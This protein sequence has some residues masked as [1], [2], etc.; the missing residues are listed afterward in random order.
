MWS[1]ALHPV[2]HL[3]W[4]YRPFHCKRS[5]FG[6]KFHVLHDCRT[7]FIL[8]FIVYTGSSTYVASDENLDVP[9]A[10]VMKLMKNN[11]VEAITYSLI[12]SIPVLHYS[13]YYMRKK[14]RGLWYCESETPWLTK[15]SSLRTQPEWTSFF[16]YWHTSGSPTDRQK[17]R[18][19]DFN[20]ARDRNEKHR[21]S[22]D[23]QTGRRIVKPI[24]V[25]DYNKN[26]GLVDKSGMQMSFS[27]CLISRSIMHA[28]YT[29][30]KPGKKL[31]F[32]TFDWT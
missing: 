3:A 19:Y 4:Q 13:K 9:G 29:N 12:T 31:L 23:N 27:I 10:I 16:P 1:F 14:H 7:G 21:E 15:F 32:P 17:W 22:I 5:R 25:Q 20:Y 28:Y 18:A 8:D 6:I 30:C 2:V 11:F 24:S 26:R